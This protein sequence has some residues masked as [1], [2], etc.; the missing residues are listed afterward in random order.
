MSLAVALLLKH[1]P[2]QALARGEW[3]AGPGP[4][5]RGNECVTH[6]DINRGYGFRGP[7]KKRATPPLIF[8][9]LGFQGCVSNRGGQLDRWT[10]ELCAHA[11]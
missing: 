7:C 6:V 10:L 5:K 9:K 1:M 3:Y 2:L 4:G 8:N 11:A